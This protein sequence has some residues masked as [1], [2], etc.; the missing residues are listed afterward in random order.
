MK[1]LHEMSSSEL[2]DQKFLL[3]VLIAQLLGE[4]KEEIAEGLDEL[5]SAVHTIIEMQRLLLQSSN[6]VNLFKEEFL[7]G[8]GKE[9]LAAH[10]SLVDCR[11]QQ[12][13]AKL[14]T[15]NLQN[16]FDK[17]RTVLYIAELWLDGQA[18]EK[19]LDLT[20]AKYYQDQ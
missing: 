14:T 9:E 15:E 8:K 4:E 3:S 20:W 5:L 11:C 17:L 12:S 6:I 18:T 19:E 2:L 13:I 1:K 16:R 7:V 10:L